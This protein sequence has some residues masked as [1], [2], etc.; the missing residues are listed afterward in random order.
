MDEKKEAQQP[1]EQNERQ[2]GQKTPS[3]TGQDEAK[4]TSS[5]SLDDARAIADRL[6]KANIELKSLLAKQE[7]IAAESLLAGRGFAGLSGT[8]EP[9]KS[10]KAKE[11][12]KG[13]EIEKAL[14]RHPQ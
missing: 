14:E 5:I 4:L 6:E 9:T 13:T 12:F 10:D 7:R 1:Q 8:K 11:F 3:P 2:E